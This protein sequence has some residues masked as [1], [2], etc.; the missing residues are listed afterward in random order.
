M[1][2][3]TAALALITL[4]LILAASRAEAQNVVTRSSGAYSAGTIP[5]ATYT[6]APSYSSWTGA[7]A[8]GTSRP[9]TS[10]NAPSSSSW[11]GAYSAGTIPPATRTN[12]PSYSYW[13][14]AY[15]GYPPRTYVGLGSKA[16]DFPYYGR[17]YGSPSD[18]WSWPA[19][20][21][22]PNG[23]PTRYYPVLP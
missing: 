15:Y 21:G 14:A 22:Y 1:K 11:T 10:T 9:T 17:P 13:T 12:A 3:T 18:P 16:N 5:P 23:V 4:S 19:M 20:A 7:Y 8:A 6:N 2:R